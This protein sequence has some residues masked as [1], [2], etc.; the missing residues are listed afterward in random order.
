[1]PQKKLIT[2]NNRGKAFLG[3]PVGGRCFGAVVNFSHNQLVKKT[4]DAYVSSTIADLI[5]TKV[6]L[7]KEDEDKIYA[8][9]FLESKTLFKSNTMETLANLIIN[10]P[11]GLY[12]I[13]MRHDKKETGH[14]IA[15]NVINSEKS[16]YFEPN[17]GV[18][19]I[20]THELSKY[21]KTHDEK[22]RYNH[23]TLNQINEISSKKAYEIMNMKSKDK[24]WSNNIVEGY[25][26]E[27]KEPFN[28][29][30]KTMF[31]SKQDFENRINQNYSINR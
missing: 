3:A 28:T 19:E 26:T 5:Q 13:E 27:T 21:F 9:Q 24:N 1:M 17:K 18:Y 30:F 22:G 16:L 10:S 7:I 11:P 31:E 6:S 2:F 25:F 4:K 15:V 23:F 14:I 8:E 29:P 20:S 12:N